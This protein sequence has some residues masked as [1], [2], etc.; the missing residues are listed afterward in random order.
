MEQVSFG[1]CITNACIP[2]LTAARYDAPLHDVID[3]VVYEVSQP[4]S[5]VKIAT[6]ARVPLE[7]EGCT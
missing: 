7:L 3:V 2:Y 1:E 5:W 6:P 4:V